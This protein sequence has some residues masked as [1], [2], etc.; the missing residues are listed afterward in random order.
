MR[1][2]YSLLPPRMRVLHWGPTPGTVSVTGAK[3]DVAENRISELSY[4]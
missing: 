1:G 2:P 3:N 4:R